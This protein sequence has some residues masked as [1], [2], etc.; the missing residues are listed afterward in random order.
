MFFN[1][2]DSQW[3]FTGIDSLANK[4]FGLANDTSL[5][6]LNSYLAENP[7]QFQFQ[8]YH[9]RYLIQQARKVKRGRIEAFLF[10]YNSTIYE[11]KKRG[12]AEQFKSA[13]CVTNAQSYMAF[14][15]KVD[16]TM[17]IK[18]MMERFD[19]EIIRLRENG[20]IRQTLQSYGLP[21]WDEHQK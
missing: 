19:R 6:E 11:L 3:H 8:P 21:D 13:G 18:R 2:I 17:R 20:F 16:H 12:I 10:T 4:Q 1:D 15:P 9:E 5:E 14:T 7:E